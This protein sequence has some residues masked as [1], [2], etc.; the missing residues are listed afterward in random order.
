M[1]PRVRIFSLVLAGITP[2]S[3]LPQRPANAG[4]QQVTLTID[5]GAAKATSSP[6]LYGLMT[7]EINHSY[8]GG[9]YAELIRDRAIRHGGWGQ[10]DHWRLVQRGVSQADLT[11]DDSTGPSAALPASLKLTVQA[12]DASSPAGIANTGWWGIPVRPRTAYHATFWAKA[13]TPGLAVTVALVD[14]D[15]GRILAQQ[16]VRGIG[17]SWQPHYATLQTPA[18]LTPSQHNHFALLVGQPA[19][20]WVNLVSLFPPTYKGTSNGNRIDLMQRMA[21]M[22]PAFLR[23]PGGNYLEGRTVA[24]RFRWEQTV[25]PLVDRPTHKSPWGYR[26]SDGMG[27]LEFLNW[28]QDLRMEPV[29]AVYAGYSLNGEHVHPG[30]ALQPYVQSALDE[31]EYVTGGPSAGWGAL[32]A[33]DGHPEPFALRYVEVGNEDQFDKSGSYSARYA[34]FY[35]AI[36]HR[37]PSLQ[38]IAT[39]PVTGHK[40]DVLDEHY[41][42]SPQQFFKMTDHYDKLPRTG[43]KIFVG[44]WATMEGTPTPD[45][46]AALSDAAWMTGLER[47]SDLVLMASYAPLLTNVNPMGSQWVPDLIGYDAMTSYGSPSYWAQVLFSEYR[48]DEILTDTIT[49]SA[50][51]IFA[52]VTRKSA[53]GTLDLKLVNAN[54]IAATIQVHL[55]HAAIPP[56][57]GTQYILSAPSTTATNSLADPEHIV[58][59]QK[60][61]TRIGQDFTLTLQPLS[62][63]VITLQPKKK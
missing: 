21:A 23:F 24:E 42:K 1:P 57:S 60:H 3:A 22:H 4:P 50:V 33:K 48:G 54:T 25:G 45:F 9:L 15:S 62:I 10:L 38:I 47:N 40:M 59:K 26:S 17:A 5:D 8:D 63:N 55:Q 31:I 61:L 16:T 53:T 41:Y 32:R 34:Q 46:G 11:I 13:S 7:E 18:A 29:L 30:D 52:S 49:G 43:P 19:T 51:R 44:E 6:T 27:L 28:C 20:M 14:D 2:L 36:H 58:P 39:A 56:A 37:Y 12:A 35:D